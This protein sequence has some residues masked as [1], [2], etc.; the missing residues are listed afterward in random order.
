MW[1][2]VAQVE[3]EGGR[4]AV[5]VE[6][7]RKERRKEEENNRDMGVQRLVIARFGGG[8]SRWPQGAVVTP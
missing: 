1:L 5:E 8:L 4:R 7:S 6:W 3:R 2:R